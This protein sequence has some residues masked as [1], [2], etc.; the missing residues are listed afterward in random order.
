MINLHQ[1]LTDATA[2]L[3]P[4]L[5]SYLTKLIANMRWED[6]PQLP[7]AR[8]WYTALVLPRVYC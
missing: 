8:V 2:D 4:N 6:S 5:L 3:E 7:V 1:E